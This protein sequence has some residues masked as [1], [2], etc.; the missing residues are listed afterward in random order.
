M[1][2]CNMLIYNYLYYIKAI[3]VNFFSINLYKIDKFYAK[4][5]TRNRFAR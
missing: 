3:E 2:F 1:L 5:T 4:I